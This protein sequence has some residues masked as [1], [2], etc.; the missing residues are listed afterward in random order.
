MKNLLP[1]LLLISLFAI[2]CNPGSRGLFAKKTQH[3][4]Y[5]DK[6]DKDDLD[7]TPAG[8]QWLAA[9]KTALTSPVAVALPYRM[10]GYF[11]RD[12]QRA[13][14]LSFN[15]RRGQKIQF[16]LD[17]RATDDFVIYADLFQPDGSE[18]KLILSG[19][20]N[21]SAFSFDVAQTGSYIL[22]LQPQ[23]DRTGNY[24]LSV[25]TGPSLSF[26]VAGT[27]ASIESLWGVNRDGGKRKHEG[28]DIFAPK[29]TPALAAA[30]G[31]ITS[32]RE[33]GIGGKVVWLRLRD[34]DVTLYYAHLDE[35]LVREGQ[36]VRTGDTLGLVGNTG[37]AKTT[38]SHLHFGIYT[39]MGAEDPL[40]FVD[41]S[42][43]KA[44]ASPD[45]KLPAQLR[46]AKNITVEGIPLKANSILI[47]LAIT[48]RG[49]LAELPD[50]RR[51][52]TPF[53]IVEAINLTPTPGPAL[54]RN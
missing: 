16:N 2:S 50:G 35:Q 6:L 26:P 15:A 34:K 18:F 3:E 31:I 23:V 9:S 45:K 43:K 20:T 12:R 29:R 51:V 47:P 33:G 49:F 8:R 5:A 54:A 4:S 10:K 24:E 42:I 25:S 19:D 28:I 11:P 14:G 21:T 52:V 40:L 37:N 39:S 17:R 53:P 41:R 36:V 38:P 46:V 32:V 22:R 30:D 1:A 27:R 13:L 48:A 44:P 7:K